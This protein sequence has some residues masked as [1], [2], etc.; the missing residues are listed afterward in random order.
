MTSATHAQRIM[1]L[2][3]QRPGLDDDEI[4]RVL[5]I[6]PRQTVNQICR[7]LAAGGAL[8]R[9]RGAGGKIVNVPGNGNANMG[10][11][12]SQA[13]VPERQKPAPTLPGS[14]VQSDL[15]RTLLI[16]PCSGAKRHRGEDTQL[17]PAITQSLKPELASEFLGARARVRQLAPFD[18]TVLLP[19]WQPL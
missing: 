15:A 19:A 2:L 7:R 10:E 8:Q 4:A 9:E 16:L 11:P 18:E 13:H 5:G 17:G 12:T 1:E 6:E 3:A 14:M